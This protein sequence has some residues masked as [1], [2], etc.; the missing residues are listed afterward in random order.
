MAAVVASRV[1]LPVMLGRGSGVILNLTSAAATMSATTPGAL[2]IGA[3]YAVSKAALNRFVVAL[4]LEMRAS[5]I[6]VFLL[7]PGT[8]MT[9]RADQEIRKG[10]RPNT[11][12]RQSME[13]LAGCR[14]IFMLLLPA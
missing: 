2:G 12:A 8:V 3:P 13:I 11:V 10:K 14:G 9:E 6:G 7:D 5:G 4:A 1:C